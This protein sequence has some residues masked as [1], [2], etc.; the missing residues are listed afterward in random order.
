MDFMHEYAFMHVG[1][2]GCAIKEF[3][4]QRLQQNFD[5]SFHGA[6]ILTVLLARQLS[7]H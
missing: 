2:H 3:S 5:V 1:H 7:I 6:A 4:Y